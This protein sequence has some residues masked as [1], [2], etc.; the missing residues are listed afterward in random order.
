[1]NITIGSDVEF[2]IQDK[3]TKELASTIPIYP[4]SK[5]FPRRRGSHL[6]SRDNIAI[7][8]AIPYAYQKE[9][10]LENFRLGFEL[11]EE[12]IGSKGYEIRP[13][14]A[15]IAPEELL[16]DAEAWVFGCEPDFDA[17]RLKHRKI[18][19]I[20]KLRAI[21]YDRLRTCGGHIHV[22][23]PDSIDKI[24]LIRIMDN[25]LGRWAA[26]LEPALPRRILYGQAGA[27]RFKPYG[28]EYRTLGNFWA[29]SPE[30]IAKVY[31]LTME[32]VSVAAA[33]N[34]DRYKEIMLSLKETR[35]IVNDTR[36]DLA[37][38]A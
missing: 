37:E 24:A 29:E 6:F 20:K 11:L 18:P 2:F 22:G 8:F 19:T 15:I 31:D 9:Q 3:K 17:Y 12:E 32:A 14:N 33:P 7:E 26:N 4:Y 36:K 30:T 5:E 35:D 23:H 1:M 34:S 25:I 27:M 16:I 10:F 21:G 38:T 28:V 13:G